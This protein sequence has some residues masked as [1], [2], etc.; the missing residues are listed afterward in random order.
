MGNTLT[1]IAPGQFSQKNVSLFG[2]P[3][4]SKAPLVCPS[5][6]T[7]GYSGRFLKI[8]C[9]GYAGGVSGGPFLR[10]FDGKR[11]D[12][13]GVIGGWKTGGTID[14]ESYSSQFDAD[15]I[16][17]YNQAVNDYAPDTPNGDATMGSS[18]LWKHATGAA[19]GTFHTSSQQFGDS[20]LIVK[21]DDG[22]VTLYPGD[23]NFGFHTGC[24]PDAPCETQL[25]K[26]NDVW[27][28]YADIIT[29]GDYAGTNAYDLLVKW[30]DG[31]VTLYPDVSEGTGLPTALDQHLPNEIILAAPHSVWEYARG[32]ATGKYG[33]NQWPDDLIVR[34]SDGEVTKYIDIDGSGLHAEE[35]LA[36]PNDQWN[37]ASLITG[38]DLDGDSNGTDPNHDLLV[39]WA[40]GT[41]SVF[42]NV[43]SGRLQNEQ[44]IESSSTWTHAS[45]IAL[46]EYGMND[47]EDDLIVRCS[48]GEVTMYG[49]TQAG[50]IGREYQLVPPPA[51]ARAAT[52]Q[53]AVRPDDPC[54]KVC[55]PELYRRSH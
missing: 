15:V 24:K 31:E 42:P 46:G 33:G 8:A 30:V 9:K 5:T 35:Q 19:S 22:E 55:G 49:K 48:D 21:W 53:R 26:P 37:T 6:N 39:V 44:V 14:D 47:W 50:A 36:A 51:A 25:A 4:G 41:V 28:N 23:Q 52:A 45:V 13:I 43:N 12:V 7:T 40:S 18:D 54:A 34:W 16:R 29:A 32:F 1:T 11:G 20:D 27:K 17:L 3:G 38:G 10:N 2:F